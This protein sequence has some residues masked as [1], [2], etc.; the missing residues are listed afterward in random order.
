MESCKLSIFS[1]GT[2]LPGV[3]IEMFKFENEMLEMKMKCGKIK[4]KTRIS[5]MQ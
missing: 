3:N 4:N 1:S 2:E 5:K